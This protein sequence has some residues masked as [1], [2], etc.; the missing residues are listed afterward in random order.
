MDDR[1]A[2]DFLIQF[3]VFGCLVV[4][5]ILVWLAMRKKGIS[6]LPIIFLLIALIGSLLLVAGQVKVY[7]SVTYGAPDDK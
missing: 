5:G 2:N 7:S 6:T 4:F 1:P 3:G